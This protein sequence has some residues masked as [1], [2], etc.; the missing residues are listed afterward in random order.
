MKEIKDDANRWRDIPCSWIGRNNLV[1]M[2]ENSTFN[3]LKLKKKNVFF[4]FNMRLYPAAN[5]IKQIS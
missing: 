5:L 2:T 1:K 4:T 3:F